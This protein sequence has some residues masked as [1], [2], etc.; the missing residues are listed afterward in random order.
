MQND[1]KCHLNLS[2][3]HGTGPESIILQDSPGSFELKYIIAF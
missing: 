2:D 1:L 3:V